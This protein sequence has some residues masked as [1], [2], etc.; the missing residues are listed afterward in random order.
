VTPVSS[1]RLSAEVKSKL[2]RLAHKYKVSRRFLL[3]RLVL[4]LDA[5]SQGRKSEPEPK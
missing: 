1:F 3:E 4:E 5:A 2:A